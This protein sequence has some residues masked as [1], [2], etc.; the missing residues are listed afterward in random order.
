MNC[1]CAECQS[2]YCAVWLN[3]SAFN[4]VP[5]K[6]MNKRDATIF[7]Q[8]AHKCTSIHNA[9]MYKYMEIWNNM[10]QMVDGARAPFIY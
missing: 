4:D 5:S 8:V 9:I 7:M 1:G 2:I 10:I 3:C 6:K